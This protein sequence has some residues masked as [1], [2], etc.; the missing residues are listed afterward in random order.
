MHGLT[1]QRTAKLGS[2]GLLAAPT[3]PFSPS[4]TPFPHS[5]HCL[6]CM[7]A[8]QLGRELLGSNGL[9]GE[10]LVSKALA[11]MEGVHSYE[12]TYVSCARAGS[13]SFS[14]KIFACSPCH[15][16][17]HMQPMTHGPRACKV[18]SGGLG[19]DG[20]G[21]C[22]ACTCCRWIGHIA[23]YWS[24]MWQPLSGGGEQEHN[25]RHSIA[26]TMSCLA[27]AIPEAEVWSPDT[28]S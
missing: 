21:F 4:P 18:Q 9:L 14:G 2:N 7:Q 12:G 5:T 8:A 26:S 10:F 27:H 20:L 6:L 3:P 28:R 22:G 17:L 13:P 25:L 1:E 24:L 19:F 15:A 16:W 11:D 23:E